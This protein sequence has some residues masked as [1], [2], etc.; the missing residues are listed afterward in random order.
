M[1]IKTNKSCGLK[2]GGDVATIVQAKTVDRAM[3]MRVNLEQRMFPQ[4]EKQIRYR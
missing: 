1:A 3:F 2:V 4:S